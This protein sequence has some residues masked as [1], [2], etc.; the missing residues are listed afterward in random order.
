MSQI[1]EPYRIW[2]N[3]PSANDIKL[4]NEQKEKAA[5]YLIEKPW[6]AEEN[7][8]LNAFDKMAEAQDYQASRPWYYILYQSDD[9]VLSRHTALGI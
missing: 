6:D 3:K 8:L 9:F 7:E 1:P 2:E 4:Q 5:N